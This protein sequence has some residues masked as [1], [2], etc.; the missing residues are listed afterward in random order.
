MSDTPARDAARG[1]SQLPFGVDISK[2]QREA[3]KSPADVADKIGMEISGSSILGVQGASASDYLPDPE[4]RPDAQAGMPDIV[5]AVNFWASGD[6]AMRQAIQ[7]VPATD[8]RTYICNV[9]NIVVEKVTAA[10]VPP[11]KP[12]QTANPVLEQNLKLYREVVDATINRLLSGDIRKDT[13]KKLM[14][15]NPLSRLPGPQDRLEFLAKY[16]GRPDDQ[17][18]EE[19]IRSSFA[20]T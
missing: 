18:I 6:P 17:A 4:Y 7:A 12:G 14:V 16:A 5:A 2:R 8:I 11:T 13:G 19:F 20:S 1:F 9:L 15:K 3:P 10:V